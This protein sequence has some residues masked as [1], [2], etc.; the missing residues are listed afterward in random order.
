[1][2]DLIITAKMCLFAEL[3]NSS[4]IE[5]YAECIAGV[6]LSRIGLSYDRSSMSEYA[7][8]LY[9]RVE[10]STAE[11][12]PEII[13]DRL[14]LNHTK[15]AFFAG[16][17]KT[18]LRRYREDSAWLDNPVKRFQVAVC[19][20]GLGD[21][22]ADEHFAQIASNLEEL[23]KAI[24]GVLRFEMTC[25]R[26]GL[27][28]IRPVKQ[29]RVSW[30][31]VVDKYP[32]PVLSE[33][34]RFD[35][36]ADALRILEAS[37]QG[38]A[39]V[40]LLLYEIARAKRLPRTKTKEYERKYLLSLGT[41]IEKWLLR[42]LS[43]QLSDSGVWKPRRVAET[44]RNFAPYAGQGADPRLPPNSTMRYGMT[45]PMEDVAT[46]L[47]IHPE[48]A[49]LRSTL[50]KFPADKL[51]QA[52]I[53]KSILSHWVRSELARTDYNVVPLLKA[54][55]IDWFGLPLAPLS[56]YSDKEFEEWRYR[57]HVSPGLTSLDSTKSALNRMVNED[58]QVE[59]R[60]GSLFIHLRKFL[61]QHYAVLV[62]PAADK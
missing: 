14:R 54:V 29:E 25:L 27:G 13:A 26:R 5:T 58:R 35:A 21:E 62:T 51:P 22:R 40:H 49:G 41:Y 60:V 1:M 23:P 16:R 6:G 34:D 19:M 52:E 9:S 61:E 17:L 56:T 24:R 32:S 47:E 20:L 15:A 36:V 18:A 55:W 45:H 10:S 39:C 44:F 12:V 42:E 33:D 3:C 59:R 57:P 48:S 31:E 37:R 50:W 7:R 43:W 46:L 2:D 38:E 4:V 11:G 53:D 8:A 30:F 28:G